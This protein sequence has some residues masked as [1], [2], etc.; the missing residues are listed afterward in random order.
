MPKTSTT[1]IFF[2]SLT[3]AT[4][5]L[6]AT[7]S[8][9]M[10]ASDLAYTNVSGIVLTNTGPTTTLTGLFIQD[11]SSVS[12]CDPRGGTYASAATAGYGIMWT[13]I[14]VINN[15]STPIGSTYLYNLLSRFQTDA[16][17]DSS[18]ARVTPGTG[19]SSGQWC[20]QLG[21]TNA[22]TVTTPGTVQT[23]IYDGLYST[24]LT[25]NYIP[26][27]CYD[28]TAT[29]PGYCIASPASGVDNQTFSTT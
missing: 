26:I 12:T 7:H 24:P 9:F 14:T 19:Q 17:L 22:A 6:S 21:I 20:I 18:A 23:L 25:A 5:A 10:T 27:F 13:N 16:A 1:L 3:A 28:P 15:A 11:V 8:G 2:I 29:I 4:Q